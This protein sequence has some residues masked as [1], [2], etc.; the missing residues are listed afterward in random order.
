[1]PF[2]IPLVVVLQQNKRTDRTESPD[3]KVRVRRQLRKY[4]NLICDLCMGTCYSHVLVVYDLHQMHGVMIRNPKM[5]TTKLPTWY[6][7]PASAA[8]TCKL[9][10]LQ[11]RASQFEGPPNTESSLSNTKNIQGVLKM[12]TLRLFLKNPSINIVPKHLVLE[13]PRKSKDSIH[14]KNKLR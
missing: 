12:L 9:N 5:H 7:H 2:R 13:R 11:L 10:K 4:C 3:V 14:V 8:F 6:L 1:M